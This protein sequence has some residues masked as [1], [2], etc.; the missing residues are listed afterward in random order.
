MKT[1]HIIFYFIGL[2]AL[3]SCDDMFEPAKENF[4]QLDDLAGESDYAHGL[5]MY[6]YGSLPYMTTT[7]TDIATDDA[8]TNLKSDTYKDMAAFGTWRSDNNPMAQWDRCKG[9]IQY[10]NLFLTIVDK[11]RWAPRA[12]SKQQMFVDRLTGEAYGLRALL[13]YYL[14]QAHGGYADD[15]V[16]YGVPLLTTP[17]DGSSDF[18]QPRATFA[19][20]VKQCFADC[21]MAISLL[22]TDYVD[23]TSDDEI[24]AKYKALGAN[25]SG[26]NLVFGIKSDGLMSG[27]IAEAVKAQIALLAASPAFR[28]QSGVT[29]AE[30][31]TLCANVLKRVGGLEGF[32]PTGNI[33]YKNTSKLG[34]NSS[35]MPEILWRESR[36]DSHNNT[37]QEGDNFPPSLYG[38]G[39][40]NPSQNL[41]DAF[42]MRNGRPITDPNSG[43]NPQ[44]PYANR[45]PRLSDN[46]I[47]NGTT[48]RRAEI[49]TGT[50]SD[51]D[52]NL[53]RR[54]TSTVTGYYM[55]KLLRED[56]SPSASGSEIK[57]WHIYPRI[58][59]TEIFL[60]YAEAANDAWGPKGDPTGVGFTAYD[61]IKAI[62]QRAGLGTNEIGMPLPEGDAYLEECAGNQDMMT[63]LIR[64]ERRL[65]LCFENKRFWDLRRWLLPLNEK[66]KGMKID[67]DKE[68]NALIYTVIDVED[69]Q[70]DSSYQC[71]GPIP[72]SEILK[73]S[74]LKQNKGWQ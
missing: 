30:A 59:Y 38:R 48:Y 58:R 47:Y 19:D 13:Y 63:N 1:R 65:E 31:A 33:W 66:V 22:P 64:N 29:S 25:P 3:C 51:N 71:Y 43:Y 54:A 2:L 23:I 70:F 5:L 20:C 45:D 28:D 11:S 24:P 6:G 62:R 44:E 26:Y 55:K 16:L 14:L 37:T 27:K 67:L 61:V 52:D 46:V 4:R 15:G 42:P 50:Y 57:Q 53:N 34:P 73:W 35:E 21:D 10:L 17:E 32:D 60:A 49:I 7:Q 68:T 9:G 56:V 18:N 72:K 69:R 12:E 40:V 41:V 74:N 39:L 8:V 36:V